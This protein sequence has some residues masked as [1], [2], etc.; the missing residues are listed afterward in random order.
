KELDVDSVP[1]NILIPIKGTPLEKVDA[2]SCADVI[3]SICLFRMILQDKA[4]KIAAGRETIFKDFQALGFMAGAN[5][6][7]VGGYLTVNGRDATDDSRL[8]REIET[9]WT[10]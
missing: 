6:M 8:M 5:G 9:L 2:I 4:I 10:T 7:L 1:V 3:R